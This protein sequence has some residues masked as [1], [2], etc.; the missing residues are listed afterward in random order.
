MA[1][2]WCLFGALPFVFGFVLAVRAQSN[3]ELEEQTTRLDREQEI[4]ARR[5]AAES[6]TG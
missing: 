2:V 3:L 4:G 5:A 6:G 1:G